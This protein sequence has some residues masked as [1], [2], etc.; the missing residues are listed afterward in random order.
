MRFFNA[1]FKIGIIDNPPI[2]I[3]RYSTWRAYNSITHPLSWYESKC[4]KECKKLTLVLQLLM[5]ELAGSFNR[6]TVSP[7]KINGRL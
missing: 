2:N 4:K 1:F 7:R 5:E 3:D 6:H